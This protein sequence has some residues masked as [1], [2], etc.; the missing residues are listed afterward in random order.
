MG[1]LGLDAGFDL[2]S[3]AQLGLNVRRIRLVNQ[4]RLRQVALLFC[5]LLC[6]D[7]RLE[8]VLALQLSRS[9]HG[10]ALFRAAFGLHLRHVVRIWR[11]GSPL[12]NFLLFRA[13][14]DEHPL[15]FQLAHQL[16]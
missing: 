6:Q 4:S 8:R 9:G 3:D 14:C 11:F 2:F 12:S 5:A 7:V 16:H 10:E 13:D 1:T 15:S